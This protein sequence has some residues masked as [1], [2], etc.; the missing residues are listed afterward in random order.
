MKNTDPVVA[1]IAIAV[2]TLEAAITLVVAALAL[3]LTLVQWRPAA[4]AAAATPPSPPPVI[5][6]RPT[7][8]QQH[9][10]SLLAMQLQGLSA[11]DLREMAVIRSKRH[12]KQQLI[13]MVIACS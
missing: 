4:P 2:I 8:P 10:L 12:T 5:K 13:G 6:A 1:L 11:A 9:P 3:L 7:P